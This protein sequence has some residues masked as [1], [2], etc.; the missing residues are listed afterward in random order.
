MIPPATVGEAVL[1]TETELKLVLAPEA[2]RRVRRHALIRRLKQGRG[3]TKT[4][5]SV[6]FDTE[7]LSLF[8]SNLVLRVRHIG[9][10]RVQTLKSGLSSTASL[11][12]RQEWETEIEGDRP[13]APPLDKATVDLPNS[14]E[15]LVRDLQPFSPL[16]SGGRPISSP[17]RAGKS[18]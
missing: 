3:A 2:L 10:K 4:L 1:P 17:P 11:L 8:H 13:E 18:S 5:K 12:G 6:Y 7:D 14:S 15:R 16:I 9:P